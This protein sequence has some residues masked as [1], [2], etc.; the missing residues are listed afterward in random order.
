MIKLYNEK[1]AIAKSWQEKVVTL[2]QELQQCLIEVK[3]HQGH[4]A[5]GEQC[6]KAATE[7]ADKIRKTSNKCV[8]QAKYIAESKQAIAAIRPS[9]LTDLKALSRVPNRVI[10]VF[11]AVLIILGEEEDF[12]WENSLR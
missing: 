4:L 1:D 6:V 11:K 10:Q 3:E 9:W 5:I 7:E 2:K 8:M 12:S